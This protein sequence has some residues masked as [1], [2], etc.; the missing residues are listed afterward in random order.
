MLDT[1]TIQQ[2]ARQLYD[3]RKSRTP[4]RQFSRQHPGMDI[5]DGYAIQRAWVALPPPRKEGSRSA[6]RPRR[7][8]AR[9]ES[10]E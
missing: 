10:G 5:D 4:L 7:G 3:A 9:G 6:Q 8:A 1:A 2:L